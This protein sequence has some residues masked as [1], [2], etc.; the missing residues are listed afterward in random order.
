MGFFIYDISFLIAFTIFVVIFLYI[1]RKN[2][3]REGLIYLYRTKIGIGFINSFSKK[4]EKALKFSKYAVVAIGFA[5]M[6]IMIYLLANS[7]MIYIKFPQITEIIKAPPV[8]PLIPYFP[9][10]FGVQ[11]LFPPF[12][13]AYFLFALLIIAVVH[14]FAHGIYMKVFK[15]K[16][17]STGFAF[18]G[19]VLGAFVEQDEKSMNSKKNSEQMAVLAAGVTSN[20][21]FAGIFF[22]L[23]V[24]F[25]LVSF[26]AGGYMFNTYA[27]TYIPLVSITGFGN[28]NDSLTAVSALNETFFMDNSMK[29]QLNKNPKLVAVYDSAPAIKAG[30]SGVIIKADNYVIKNHNDLAIFLDGKKPGDSIMLTTL[31]KTTKKESSYII[32]LAKNP[33]NSSKPYLGIGFFESKSDKLTSRVMNF[34][35]GFKEGSTYYSAKYDGDIALFIYNLLWWIT[36]IN[37][38]VALFNMLPLGILD[39]GRFFYLT[40]F[41]LTKSEKIAKRAYSIATYIILG[42]FALLMF[43]WLIRIL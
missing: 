6:A 28:M 32:E 23:M 18:L 43:F 3:K 34:F 37:L 1:K 22:L 20:L 27:I 15:I 41:S 31:D 25:F 40:I 14:E 13:F 36:I 30:L 4:F 42:I 24:G 26:Q 29:T 5:L 17:K 10:I 16:I 38:F 8:A 9:Q 39:G 33:A 35:S 2:L 21:I 12:Y 7:L 19:P 11:S